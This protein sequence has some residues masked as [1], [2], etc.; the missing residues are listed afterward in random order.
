[1]KREGNDK[2]VKRIHL[3]MKKIQKDFN[4]QAMRKHKP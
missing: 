3:K 4:F 1:M 2:T